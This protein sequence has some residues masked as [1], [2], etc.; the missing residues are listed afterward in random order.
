MRILKDMG[1]GLL[2]RLYLVK[3]TLISTDKSK[4]LTDPEL[5]VI[6]TK[7]EKKFPVAIEFNKVSVS[8]YST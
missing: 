8:C 1:D 3:G 6:R 5:L 4:L 2:N 7:L